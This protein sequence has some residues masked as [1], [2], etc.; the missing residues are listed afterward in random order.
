[1]AV[2]AGWRYWRK[3]PFIL[4]GLFWYFGTM[5]PVGGIFRA[6]DVIF[7]DRYSYIP[8][9]GFLIAVV[10][11]V[12]LLVNE[13]NKRVIGGL[14]IASIAV[15]AWLT[16]DYV[17]YWADGATLF[18]RCANIYPESYKLNV[19]AGLSLVR[20]EDPARAISYYQAALKALPDDEHA[21]V[22]IGEAYSVIGKEDLA[23]AQFKRALVLNPSFTSA[24]FNLATH[25]IDK[26]EPQ[27]A[28]SLLNLVIKS[29]PKN[30]VAYYWLGKA[31]LLKNEPN[32]AAGYFRTALSINPADQSAA[33]ELQKLGAH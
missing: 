21:T 30:G 11:S 10:W 31:S 19:N 32:E 25:L 28:I 22:L 2:W 17:S 15:C 7:A 26:G 16:I 1:L 12:G 27:I 24:Q 4:V 33:A 23:I 14:A 8:Q 20:N 5:V 29:S 6:G 3:A 13:K 9:I 18:T